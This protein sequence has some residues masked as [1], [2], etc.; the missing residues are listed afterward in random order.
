MIDPDKEATS[1]H[2]LPFALAAE[3]FEN[4]F[5]EEIDA[6]FDYGERRLKATGR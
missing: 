5:V 6:R 1:G 3:L 2:G 4:D